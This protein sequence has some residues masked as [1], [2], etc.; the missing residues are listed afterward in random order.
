M[1]TASLRAR[2]F[3]GEQLIGVLL[4]MPAEETVEMCAIA[5]FDFVLIDCE[6]GPS[7]IV[8]LRHHLALASLHGVPSIVR[9]GEHEPQLILRALDQGAEGILA[10]HVDSADDGR[11]IVEAT[12]Y[13]PL[14]HRGFATYSRAGRFGTRPAVEHLRIYQGNTL[15]VGMIES[16]AAV[17]AAPEIAAVRGMDGLM[18]GPAD[19]AAASTADDPSV[20]DSLRAVAEASASAGKLT[21]EIVNT[22]EAAAQSFTEGTSFVV[23]NLASALMT[24]LASL[25]GARPGSA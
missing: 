17:S 24:H 8:A 10:P 15:L 7:D 2:A 13:P 9:V 3:A 5:G 16:P 20:A 25:A 6:H 1:S 11:R 4:R 18:L 21:M 22:P 12:H 14:G 19:L 23:Y